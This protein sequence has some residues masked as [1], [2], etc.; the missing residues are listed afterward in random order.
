[1]SERTEDKRYVHMFASEEVKPHRGR[2][3]GSTGGRNY[4]VCLVRQTGELKGRRCG[5]S[6]TNTTPQDYGFRDEPDSSMLIP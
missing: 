2:T 1:M 3:E 4:T 6:F 5:I